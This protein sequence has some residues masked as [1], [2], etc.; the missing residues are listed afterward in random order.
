MRWGKSWLA[1]VVLAL[2][3]GCLSVPMAFAAAPANDNLANRETLSGVLPIAATGS[4]VEATKEAGEY[5]TGFEEPAGHSV[6]FSWE[7]QHTEWVTVGT[8][9]SGFG[10]L[11]DVYTGSSYANLEKVP[12][13]NE[14]PDEACFP[15]GSEATIHALTGTSYAIRVDGNLSPQAPAAK[16][17]PIKLQIAP[18]PAPANDSFSN[19]RTVTAESLSGGT[20]YRVDVSGFNWNATKEAGE[21]AHAG[22]P[23]GASVWFSWTAPAT[24]TA[25]VNAVGGVLQPLIGAYTGD[26]VGALTPVASTPAFPPALNV[27]I[28]A[29]ATYRFAV[30]GRFDAAASL[31]SMGRLTFLIYLEVPPSLP[32]APIDETRPPARPAAPDTVIAKRRIRP[33]KRTATFTFR[34]SGPASTFLCKLD[35]RKET[36]C[37]PT[38]EYV[39]LAPGSHTLWVRAIDAAGNADA[40]PA[41]AHFSIPRRQHR[42]R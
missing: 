41:V 34:S 16:E 8:C 36:K 3:C 39:A 27:P 6:W 5:N 18:T 11:V 17:G 24:G 33:A 26:S 15:G 19:A 28:V 29:G 42:H 22:D 40:T 10:S 25:T 38:S 37:A 21:P 23:G 7:A 30:D 32:S 12:G 2:S 31:A 14:G 4:N 20:F 1:T 13:S 35:G 9:G